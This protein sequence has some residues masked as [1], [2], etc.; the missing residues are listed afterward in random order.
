MRKPMLCKSCGVVRDDSNTYRR[1]NG[2]LMSLCK[3]CSKDSVIERIYSRNTMSE[4]LTKLKMHQA[5]VSRIKEELKR[6]RAGK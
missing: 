2:Y 4:L 6:R 3:D 5:A 1:S